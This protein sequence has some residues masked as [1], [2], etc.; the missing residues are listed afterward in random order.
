MLGVY[1]FFMSRSRGRYETY[2]Y[3]P[4]MSYFLYFASRVILK[5]YIYIYRWVPGSGVCVDRACSQ[6]PC[7]DRVLSKKF[8]GFYDLR[9]TYLL[10]ARQLTAVVVGLKVI[11]RR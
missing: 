5:I 2:R 8:I 1:T 4:I 10:D 11:F 7:A 6:K 3:S 9:S